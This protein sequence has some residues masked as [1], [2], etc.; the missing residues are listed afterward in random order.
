MYVG[1]CVHMYIYMYKY[2]RKFVYICMYIFVYIYIYVYTSGEEAGRSALHLYDDDV[3]LNKLQWKVLQNLFSTWI[4]QTSQYGISTE[5]KSTN[6]KSCIHE[7][8]KRLIQ[9]Y[10]QGMKEWH[11]IRSLL[12]NSP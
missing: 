3:F 8:K 1:I 7:R 4:M 10:K 11:Q 6:N 9:S 2:M 5:N 12:I